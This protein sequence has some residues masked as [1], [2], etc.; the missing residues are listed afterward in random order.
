MTTYPELET[1]LDRLF[2]AMRGERIERSVE[3]VRREL[4]AA[5]VSLIA[6]RVDAELAYAA[7][8]RSSYGRGERDEL[9]AHRSIEQARERVRNLR[10]ELR[11]LVL[12][13]TRTVTLQAA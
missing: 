9:R 8:G 10:R 5:V 2:A 12:S 7:P 4:T 13:G 11:S 3:D 1:T 6:A